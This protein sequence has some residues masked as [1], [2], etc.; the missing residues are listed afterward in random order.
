MKICQKVNQSKVN[1]PS[2]LEG[3]GLPCEVVEEPNVQWGDNEIFHRVKVRVKHG[4]VLKI[5]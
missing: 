5:S 3:E 4:H 2:P 1:S